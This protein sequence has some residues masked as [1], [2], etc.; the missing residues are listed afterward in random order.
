L[1]TALITGIMGFIGSHLAKKLVEQNVEVY[2]LVR[3]VASRNMEVIRDLMEDVTIISG[4]VSD[5]VSTLNAVKIANPDVIFHLAALSPVRDSFERPFEYQQANYI[6]TMNVAHS[7][8]SLQDPQTRKVIAASTAEVYG[9]QGNKM[10]KETMSLH[11]SSPYAVSKAAGDLYLQMMFSSFNLKGTILRPTNS[12][13]RKHDITF[14]V[15]YLVTQMLNGNK[16]YIGSPDSLRDYMY[17][18]DHVNSYLMSMVQKK[19]NGQVFNVG[20][21]IGVSNKELA[22]MIAEKTG[23]DKKNLVLG[24]YPPG[25]PYRPLISDQPSIVMEAAKIRDEMGWKPTVT[26][27]EGIDKVIAYFQKKSK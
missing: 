27:S 9:L 19:A 10:L 14:I 20:T 3:R 26:L 22:I 16:V 6:G 11:P 21:G 24:S 13:G 8:L 4:D 7:L 1:T 23:F 5:Y 18:D 2:G 15:E 17:V 25:Y 12:Y